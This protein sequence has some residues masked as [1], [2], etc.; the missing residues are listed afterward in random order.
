M[1]PPS[2]IISGNSFQSISLADIY[3]SCDDL[4]LASA[5]KSTE[6]LEFDEREK[7]RKIDKKHV[8]E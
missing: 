4:T 5:F 6:L 8:S 7:A 2:Y 3:F 1:L